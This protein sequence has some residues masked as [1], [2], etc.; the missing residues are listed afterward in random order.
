MTGQP[1]TTGQFSVIE[2][3]KIADNAFKLIGSDWMLITAGTLQSF[4]MMTASWGALGVLWHKNVCFCFVRP[5]RHTRQFMESQ[6]T[7]T[8]SFFDEACRDALNYCGTHSGKN[9]NNK[10]EA[11]GLTPVELAPGMVTFAEARLVIASKKIYFQDIDPRNFLDA[12]INEHYPSKDYHR[13][14]VG[15]IDKCFAK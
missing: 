13:M 2:P 11:A 3:A 6:K 9:V 14:Y 7:F 8:L 5:G 12:D 1:E 15:G 4:N 10:A